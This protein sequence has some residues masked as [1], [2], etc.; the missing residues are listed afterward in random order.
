VALDAEFIAAVDLFVNTDK[1]LIGADDHPSWST[2]RDVDTLCLKL[3]LEVNGEI[4]GQ[5]LDIQTRPQLASLNFSISLIF[6]SAICR[7]DYCLESTHSN[8]LGSSSEGLTSLI[9]G[10]HYHSW[11]ANKAYIG[12]KNKPFKLKRAVPFTNARMFDAALRWFCGENRIVLP[13]MHTIELPH[14]SRLI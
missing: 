2:G 7:L 11:E 3:P 4:M 14:R 5:F 8:P 9:N 6:Q 1:Y 12:S 10:P 13:P